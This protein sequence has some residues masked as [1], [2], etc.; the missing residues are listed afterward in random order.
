M[1]VA[2]YKVSW[3][4]FQEQIFINRKNLL[5]ERL[6]TDVILVS[7]DLIPI[8]AHKT[9]L[10]AA[11]PILKKLLMI[12][13][14]TYKPMIFMK[15]LKHKEIVSLLDF[16]YLGKIALFQEEV[17]NFLDICK[18]LD[19]ND[20]K[21]FDIHDGYEVEL[22]EELTE[23]EEF[24]LKTAETED[25]SG[26]LKS[27]DIVTLAR[28]EKP[29]KQMKRKKY[30]YQYA[31]TQCDKVLGQKIHLKEHL[32]VVHEQGKIKCSKCDRAYFHNHSLEQ[33]MMSVHG[34]TPFPY[35]CKVSGC[36]K[37]F[38]YSQSS[39]RHMKTAHQ[40]SISV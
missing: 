26:S 19:I 22:E 28:Y 27:D 25:D 30:Q 29:H 5:E 15:S 24:E 13:D 18:D 23:E 40:D 38:R 39:S 34:S 37:R 17:E 10:S 8:E 2:E 12:N 31:C 33:H 16:I 36:G 14:S 1:S 6:F 21:D 4:S 32:K 20:G 3:N 7:D 9:V 11:S 35:K